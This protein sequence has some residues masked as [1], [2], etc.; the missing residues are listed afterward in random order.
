[1][2]TTNPAAPVLNLTMGVSLHVSSLRH[3]DCCCRLLWYKEPTPEPVGD[4]ESH[5]LGNVEVR[6][7]ECAACARLTTAGVVC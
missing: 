6:S 2:R 1:V 7:L 3:H 5:L 4:L